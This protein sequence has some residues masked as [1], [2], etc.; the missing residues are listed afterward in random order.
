MND[1]NQAPIGG[2]KTI[3]TPAAVRQAVAGLEFQQFTHVE[4]R[5][6]IAAIRQVALA[7]ME[8]DRSDTKGPRRDRIGDVG[9]D[10]GW[11]GHYV[12]APDDGEGLWR[13][14]TAENLALEDGLQPFLARLTDKQREALRLFFGG[15]LTERQAAAVLGISRDS[16]RDRRDGA[17]KALRLMLV[18]AFVP[19]TPDPSLKEEN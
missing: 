19:P 1:L 17:L 6:R 8:D 14:R 7:Q 3:P 4:D 15:Q 2:A 16:A 11:V 10:G 12:E 18:G 13:R 9:P 5:E